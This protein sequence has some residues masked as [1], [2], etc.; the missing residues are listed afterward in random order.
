MITPKIFSF[1]PILGEEITHGINIYQLFHLFQRKGYFLS[2]V[3]KEN[4]YYTIIKIMRTTC[5]LSN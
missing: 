3:R 1:Q 5:T 2:L 4:I